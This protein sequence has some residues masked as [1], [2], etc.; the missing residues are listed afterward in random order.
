M[1]VLRSA[2]H[3]CRAT[4]SRRP[5]RRRRQSMTTTLDYRS[6]STEQLK[7]RRDE[8]VHADEEC[9][10]TADQEMARVLELE[11]L[12]AALAERGERQ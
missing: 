2:S 4:G 9:V 1:L 10:W 5:P 12:D 6:L 8:L 7:K 11:A 3:R